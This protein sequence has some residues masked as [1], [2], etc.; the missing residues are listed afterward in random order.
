M[1]TPLSC[2]LVGPTLS[3]HLSEFALQNLLFAL[4]RLSSVFIN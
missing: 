2:I 3:G 1:F 4:A